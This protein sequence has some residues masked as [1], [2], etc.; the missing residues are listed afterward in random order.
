MKT[1]MLLTLIVLSGC[2]LTYEEALDDIDTESHTL[3]DTMKDEEEDA[4]N[5]DI[6]E[7][8]E[9]VPPDD[10]LE[11]FYQA[12]VEDDIE[13]ASTYLHAEA[14]NWSV[15]PQASVDEWITMMETHIESNELSY[16]EIEITGVEAI[17]DTFAHGRAVISATSSEKEERI[18]EEESILLSNKN[19][20]WE[21]DMAG[22]REA[23]DLDE[24]SQGA[25][26]YKDTTFYEMVEGLRID[27]QLEASQDEE[28]VR[29]GFGENPA[30]GTLYTEKGT[31]QSELSP[32]RENLAVMEF[33][34]AEGSPEHLIIDGLYITEEGRI[35]A[36]E[37]NQQTLTLD[38]DTHVDNTPAGFDRNLST[39]Q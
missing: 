31:F 26:E 18:E 15:T 36:P 29:L 21:V 7:E 1:T 27:L 38:M 23:N 37:D 19:G 34:D 32:G 9:E 28:D 24:G 35:P 14:F 8:K 17:D 5:D 10:V 33:P 25:I 16:E 12:M 20:N 11:A 39:G 6:G 13:K 3:A 22:V 2:G 4:E 30:M